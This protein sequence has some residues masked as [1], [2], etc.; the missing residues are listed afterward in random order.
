MLPCLVRAQGPLAGKVVD[1]GA[2]Q[3]PLSDQAR[4]DLAKA[5]K[6][7]DYKAEKAVLEAAIVANPTSAELF[8]VLGRLAYLERQPKEAADSLHK[9]DGIKTL[10][11]TDR[12]TLAL[13]YEFSGRPQEGRAELLR[14]VKG[15][16]DNPEYHYLL[17]RI[18]RQNQQLEEA[19][20]EFQKSIQLNAEALETYEYLGQTQEDLGLLDEAR[21]TYAEAVRRNRLRPRPAE[22]PPFNL[23]LLLIKQGDNE[24]ALKSIEEA[25]RYNPRSGRSHYQLG[26][27]LQKQGKD[28]EAVAEYQ[29]AV[30]HDPKLRPAWLALGREYTR[31]GKTEDAARALAIF[32]KLEEQQRPAE[33]KK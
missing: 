16:P 26:S 25:L 2:E 33:P 19:A 13:A 9:A 18:E 14:L 23:G 8:T 17:G 31:M 27:I 11:E 32:Q 12:V 21:K 28:A 5:V 29:L 6:T 22:T 20:G 30:V 3:A 7:H 1:I 10:S 24:R 15:A 4:L